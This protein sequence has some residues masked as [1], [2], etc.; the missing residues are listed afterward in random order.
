[1]PLLGLLG[2]GGLASCALGGLLALVGVAKGHQA[3]ELDAAVKVES[4]GELKQLLALVPLIVAVTGRVMAPKPCRCEMS[5]CEAAIVQ[6]GR[7]CTSFRCLHG[8]RCAC[9]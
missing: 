7:G 5:E 6:V 3:R 4:L 8:T 2:Y 9:Y 1:M